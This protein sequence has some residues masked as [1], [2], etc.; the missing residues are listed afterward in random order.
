MNKQRIGAIIVF[1]LIVSIVLVG[2][3]IQNGLHV[4]E[5][6]VEKEIN[7]TATSG[8]DQDLE[9]ASAGEQDEI[10][11]SEADLMPFAS[12]E[13]FTS[14]LK[15]A[16]E[17]GDVADLAMLNEY[18]LPAGIPDEYKLYKITA[19]I[20][21]IGFWYLPE[22]YLVSKDAILSAEAEQKHFLFISPRRSSSM[23]NLV[24][25]FNMN[26]NELVD[27]SYYVHEASTDIILWE[28]DAKALTLYMPI[29]YVA[30]AAVENN[31]SQ[32]CAVKKVRAR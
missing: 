27:E 25:Q 20:V 5:A 3:N 32:I 8:N 14:Y 30:E 10:F 7:S 29:D 16:E 22:E 12:L 23:D 2:C 19:G 4:D 24:E 17:G 1:F 11:A 6:Y 9:D 28:E 21:D 31:I 15:N 18:Y 26:E 13:E